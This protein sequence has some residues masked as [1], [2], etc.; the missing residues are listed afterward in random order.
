MCRRGSRASLRPVPPPSLRKVREK[1]AKDLGKTDLEIIAFIA[2]AEVVS[3][4]DVA[5]RMGMSFSGARKALLRLIDA[6]LVTCEGQGKRTRYMLSKEA[7]GSRRV[8]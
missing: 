8:P 2:K 1:C 3:N 7:M 6:E 4:S 5:E